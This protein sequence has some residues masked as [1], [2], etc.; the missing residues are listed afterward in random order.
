MCVAIHTE[1]DRIAEVALTMYF[2]L[3]GVEG[4]KD[5]CSDTR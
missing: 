5:V 2:L 3:L 1:L 4:G